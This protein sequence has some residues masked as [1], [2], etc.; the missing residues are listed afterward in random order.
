MQGSM[1]GACNE[2][3]CWLALEPT[4]GIEHINMDHYQVA[5]GVGGQHGRGRE[6]KEGN[7]V[8]REVEPFTF[9]E[10]RHRGEEFSALH[11]ESDYLILSC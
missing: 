2:M 7:K 10:Q 1:S 6:A 5:K 4:E 9:P 3:W 8:H 11:L